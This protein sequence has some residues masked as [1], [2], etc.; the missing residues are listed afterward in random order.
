M[1]GEAQKDMEK[2]KK[3]VTA[4]QEEREAKKVKIGKDLVARS[5]TRKCSDSKEGTEGD[6]QEANGEDEGQG[7]LPKK[8]RTSV[9]RA[10]GASE[11][12][13]E[14]FGEV[15]RGADMARLPIDK[16]RLMMER[17]RVDMQKM[18]RE[19]ERELR[20]EERIAQHQLELEKLKMMMNAF[21]QTKK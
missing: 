6:D 5:L 2:E 3:A 15:L 19:K 16:E 13:L 11:A 1:M 7:S 17:E 18:N 21:M 12:E 10:G 8:R 4:T 14:S 9:V 20:R